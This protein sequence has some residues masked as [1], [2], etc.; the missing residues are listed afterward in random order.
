MRCSRRSA[1]KIAR[2]QRDG[3][4]RV[5]VPAGIANRIRV[6]VFRNG[7]LDASKE[8]DARPLEGGQEI[9]MGRIIPDPLPVVVEGMVVDVEGRPGGGRGG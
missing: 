4:F 7:R 6:N 9:D 8:V 1:A 2:L 5:T 3:R